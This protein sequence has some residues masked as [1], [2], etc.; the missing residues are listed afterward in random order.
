LYS[1]VKHTLQNNLPNHT[2]DA[3]YKFYAKTSL[4]HIANYIK[5]KINSTIPIVYTGK[6]DTT[7]YCGTNTL[8]LP[9]LQPDKFYEGIDNVIE[10]M[11]SNVK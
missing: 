6:G 7:P 4:V 11:K 1:I 5:E 3:V 9:E 10:Y 2:T 8:D